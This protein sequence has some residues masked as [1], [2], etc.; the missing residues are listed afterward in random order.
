MKKD[1]L[2]LL[3]EIDPA[4]LTPGNL[5][6]SIRKNFGLTLKEIEG[7]TGIKESNL[8]AIENDRLELTKHYAEILGAALGIHPSSLLFPNGYYKKSKEIREIERK[9]VALLVKKKKAV[10]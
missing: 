3:N 1:F 6:R 10:G 9:S 5:I 7:L 8:S 2:R 4:E